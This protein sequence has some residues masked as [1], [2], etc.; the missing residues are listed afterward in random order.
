MAATDNGNGKKVA[1]DFEKMIHEARDRKKNE[2][3]AAKIF[4]RSTSSKPSPAGNLSS[5]AG[6]KKNRADSAARPR[7]STG[8]IET[9][10]TH[11][12]H[13][14]VNPRRP[15]ANGKASGSGAASLASR[16]TRPGERPP[17]APAAQRQQRRAAQV[18][19]ALI[20]SELQA[21]PHSAPSS[22]A[23]N[24]A[25]AIP[26]GPKAM[27]AKKATAKPAAAAVPDKG[28][29]IRGLAGPFVVLAQNFAPGT[30]AADIESAMTPVGGLISSCRIVKTH[31]IVIA[32]IVFENKEGADRVIQTFND[33]VA[34]G[35]VLKVFHKPGNTPSSASVPPA[36]APTGPRAASAVNDM[37]VDGSYGFEDPMET[38]NNNNNSGG[39]SKPPP[40]GPAAD[41]K[42]GR[43]YSDSM[44]SR[45]G[46][47]WKQHGR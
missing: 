11:D 36:N 45:R 3:L 42:S 8:S 27:M 1:A 14:T 5:R 22:P 40:T 35:R 25:V 28:F 6:V 43:L 12:L 37:V 26:T 2:A 15:A 46:R 44:V 47:G 23:G 4:G 21:H 13:D 17:T 9:E 16:I 31:P 41:A 19:R 7:H 34:D 24:G 33:R 32:E 10:W 20:K 29:T 39:F 38:D 18:A 30:T